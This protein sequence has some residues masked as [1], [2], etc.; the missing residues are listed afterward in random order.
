MVCPWKLQSSHLDSS[1]IFQ[2]VLSHSPVSSFFS[3]IHN[4]TCIMRRGMSQSLHRDST[5]SS[6]SRGREVLLKSGPQASLSL[7]T[8]SICSSEYSGFHSWTFCRIS[9][10][11]VSAVTGTANMPRVVSTLTS[12]TWSWSRSAISAAPF[13]I[14]PP[15][16]SQI[17]RSGA[18]FSVKITSC[19]S[20]SAISAQ[21]E[22][23][24][25]ERAE[26]AGRGRATE[27]NRSYKLEPR[28]R[29]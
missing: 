18:V 19:P 21:R 22:G 1:S 27:A 7:H 14:R 16:S 24:E 13:L 23:G 28:S 26:G 29:S 20:S 11:V 2:N 3:L 5:V 10:M 15:F 17:S 8:I 9:P 25:A 4:A 6:S 12:G